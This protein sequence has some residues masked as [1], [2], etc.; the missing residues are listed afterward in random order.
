LVSNRRFAIVPSSVPTFGSIS[1]NAPELMAL[2]AVL[3]FCAPGAIRHHRHMDFPPIY[4]LAGAIVFFLCVVSLAEW[5]I[6]SY[7][8]FHG[9]NIERLY[10]F[11]GLVTSVGAIWLGITRHWN[12]V[13][14]VSAAAFVVFLFT[15]LYHW[16]WDWMPK[17]LFFAAIGALG[18]ALVLIFKRLRNQMAQRGVPV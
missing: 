13:V 2:L 4:R 11:V 5:G 7:L 10:E 18:I 1:V 16:W 17:Y 9:E 12:G 3:V 6:P 8:P 15:R 14:N